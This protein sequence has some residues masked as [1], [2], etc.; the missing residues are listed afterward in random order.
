MQ[1][2]Y[3]GRTYTN[4]SIIISDIIRLFI[5]QTFIKIIFPSITSMLQALSVALPRWCRL[6]KAPQPLALALAL[7]LALEVRSVQG[8][9]GTGYIIGLSSL[10]SRLYLLVK[11][12]LAV[13]SLSSSFTLSP[14]SSFSSSP[15]STLQRQ[16]H[17]EISASSC[18]LDLSSVD[19]SSIF[20]Q[21]YLNQ[22][23]V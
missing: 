20:W 4:Y 6:H 18:L 3:S 14:N 12:S 11:Q 10:V 1:Q 7:A 15:T 21:T 16:G 19:L 22:I 5:L 9:P 17:A 13:F 23:Y 8:T 2:Y